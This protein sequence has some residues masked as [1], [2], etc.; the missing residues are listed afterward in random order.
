MWQKMREQFGKPKRDDLAE[1]ECGQRQPRQKR[2]A[3]CQPRVEGVFECH[4]DEWERGW[5]S[6]PHILPQVQAAFLPP[7]RPF[8]LKEKDSPNNGTNPKNAGC[9]KSPKQPALWDVSR[10]F[11]VLSR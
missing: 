10:A 4:I 6:S 5:K 3:A 8:T 1:G 2:E 7:H 11:F 9:L